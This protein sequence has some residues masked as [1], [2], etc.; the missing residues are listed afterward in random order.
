M[1]EFIV[2][3]LAG[4]AVDKIFLSKKAAPGTDPANPQ[5]AITPGAPGTPAGPA[6]NIL[7]A[8]TPP[9]VNDK[10]T[11]L[12][13]DVTPVPPNG[14]L[15][16]ADTNA[17][18]AFVGAVGNNGPMI[19]QVTQISG[20]QARGVVQNLNTSQPLFGDFA[21]SAVKLVQR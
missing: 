18:L 4:V 20:A 19:L 12:S 6:P 2:G 15:S 9:Q 7:P 3:L 21:L 14:P 13:N 17:L 10:V 5:G 1:L 11:V 16:A 8:G